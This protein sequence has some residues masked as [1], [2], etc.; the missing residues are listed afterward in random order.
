MRERE[1]NTLETKGKVLKLEVVELKWP[2]L[3]QLW[4]LCIMLIHVGDM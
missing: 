1:R 4:K 2:A 3:V